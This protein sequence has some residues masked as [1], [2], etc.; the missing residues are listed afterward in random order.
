[1]PVSPFLLRLPPIE[2]CGEQRVRAE[3]QWEQ[4]WTRTGSI[5]IESPAAARGPVPASAA[6]RIPADVAARLSIRSFIF[7]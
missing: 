7:P 3:F 4:L 6:G 1:V 5:A 2:P